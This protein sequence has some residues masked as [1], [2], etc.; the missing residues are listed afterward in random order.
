MKQPVIERVEAH[1][2]GMLLAE[3]LKD[4]PHIVK[5]YLGVFTL[6]RKKTSRRQVE[7]CL[8]IID[9]YY[10]A[11]VLVPRIKYLDLCFLTCVDAKCS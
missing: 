11:K 9:K 7:D 5:K 8:K 10:I 4:R 2:A 6:N 3:D 1:L